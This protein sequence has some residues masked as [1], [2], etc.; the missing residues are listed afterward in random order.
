MNMI[1]QQLPGKHKTAGKKKQIMAEKKVIFIFF[2]V[3]MDV[4]YNAG[5]L[6]YGSI[7]LALIMISF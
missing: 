5:L 6:I 1:L 7:L 2:P 4:N 3:F